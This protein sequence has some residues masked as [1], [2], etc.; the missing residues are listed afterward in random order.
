M[1]VIINGLK[2]S[3]KCWREKDL[4]LNR[5]PLKFVK[6]GLFFLLVTNSAIKEA[7]IGARRIPFR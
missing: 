2:K 5:A 7:V 1:V 3:H 6:S 4:F